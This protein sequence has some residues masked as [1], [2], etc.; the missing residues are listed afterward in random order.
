MEIDFNK[1]IG[2]VYSEPEEKVDII[3]VLL[4]DIKKELKKVDEKV[5]KLE[6]KEVKDDNKSKD[7]LE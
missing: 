5:E 3:Q 6:K 2:A 1:I 7:E 4:N